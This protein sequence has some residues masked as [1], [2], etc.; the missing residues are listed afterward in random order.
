MSL[1]QKIAL[2]KAQEA[3]ARARR[4]TGKP[5]EP[6]KLRPKAKDYRA[7]GDRTIGE[8]RIKNMFDNA[9]LGGNKRNKRGNVSRSPKQR[10]ADVRKAAGLKKPSPWKRD[11][12]SRNALGTEMTAKIQDKKRAD[13]TR[14][15]ARRQDTLNSV[16]DNA[17][18]FAYKLGFKSEMAQIKKASAPEDLRAAVQ[19][20]HD[21]IGTKKLRK[22]PDTGHRR[23]PATDANMKSQLKAMLSE[24][25]SVF[26][27]SDSPK[28]QTLSSTTG[29]GKTANADPSTMS[30]SA[31]VKE[32][33][34]LLAKKR[35]GN[36]SK[37][38]AS[39]LVAIQAESSL[40]GKNR[41]EGKGG[42]P[43]KISMAKK[44]PVKKAAPA[45]GESTI[46]DPKGEKAKQN[47]KEG[48]NISNRSENPDQKDSKDLTDQ[49]LDDRLDRLDTLERDLL[50]RRRKYAD[51]PEELARIKKRLDRITER[52][53]EAALEKRKRRESA[54]KKKVSIPKDMKGREINDDTDLVDLPDKDF[55]K[56]DDIRMEMNDVALDTLMRDNLVETIDNAETIGEMMDAMEDLYLYLDE[57]D[58]MGRNTSEI[59]KKLDPMFEDLKKYSDRWPRS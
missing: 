24:M 39:R 23:T 4:G 15:I 18:V 3:S 9:G 41:K 58:G 40:R 52:W 56:I 8:R 46:S 6:K 17:Q 47:A 43:T 10:A 19:K 33:K 45:R 12:N 54:S 48:G 26:G 57:W 7:A 11:I 37:E 32:R 1:A 16:R 35:E 44:E 21:A 2:K 22:A 14:N 30:A 28:P 55:N 13:T 49:E 34:E 29:S 50:A 25:D 51:D 20:L 36:L 59:R 42:G 53:D 27:K 31:I 5:D 38:E